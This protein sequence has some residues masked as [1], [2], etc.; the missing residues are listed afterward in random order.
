MN[1]MHSV[2]MAAQFQDMGDHL[3][4]LGTGWAEK[5]LKLSLAMIVVVKVV[6][7]F[8]MKAGIGALLGLVICNGIYSARGDLAD[9][10]KNELLNVG[11]AVPVHAPLY[12]GPGPH[13]ATPAERAGGERA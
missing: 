8:S 6:Q 13:E 11:A 3:L 1:T 9:Y 10:F 4:G 5:T 7:K 12:P 2:V